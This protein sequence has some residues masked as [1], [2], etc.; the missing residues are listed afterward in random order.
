[1]TNQVKIAVMGASGRMGQMLINAV[2]AHEDTVL[3]GVIERD[4]HDWVGKDLGEMMSGS[5]TGITVESDPLE[6]FARSQA[7]IDFTAPAS[8]VNFAAL[9][10]Q[11][12]L[13]HVI[14]TTKGKGFQ[15]VVKRHGFRGVGDATHGQHNRMRAPG[16]IGACATPSKVVK[17]LKMAGRTGNKRVKTK[18]LEV[19][20][21]LSDKN[22][23]LIKGCVPGHKGAFVIVEK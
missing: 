16:A 21:I 12:R 19:V 4:G 18:N 7:V 17:G 10:A 13:V 5:K 6:V 8:T 20:K 9:A 22:L 14:G 2:N 1:M 11:A 15:G 3:S 23:L